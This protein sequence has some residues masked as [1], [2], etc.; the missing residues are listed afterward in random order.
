MEEVHPI[1]DQGQI[2]C[3]SPYPKPMTDNGMFSNENTEVQSLKWAE[4]PGDI[5][6]MT[7]G[8]ILECLFKTI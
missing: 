1:D 3:I 6:H 5:N 2:G 4:S 8:M 7:D